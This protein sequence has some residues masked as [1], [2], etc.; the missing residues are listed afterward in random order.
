[1]PPIWGVKPERSIGKLVSETGNS[2]QLW[3]LELGFRANFS[4]MSNASMTGI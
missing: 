3:V 4:K 1:M 2:Q